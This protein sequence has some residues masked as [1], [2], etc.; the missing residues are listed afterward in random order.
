MLGVALRQQDSRVDV[1]GPAPERGELVAPY[2]NVPD[3]L[4]VGRALRGR[5]EVNDRDPNGATRARARRL[6]VAGATRADVYRLHVAVEIAGRDLERLL[7]PVVEV[8][9]DPV[10]VRAARF[11]VH[12]DDRLGEV[13][14]GRQ[15]GE[16]R[17]VAERGAVNDG[18]PAGR[19][20]FQVHGEERGSG[21][22]DCET[23]LRLP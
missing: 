4:G 17:G 11:L 15:L 7:A 9:P 13:V 1:D 19:Q 18:R 21:G 8:D 20:L 16:R 12:V 3:P 14:S 2:L 5:D 23:R 10:A 6:P 22:R